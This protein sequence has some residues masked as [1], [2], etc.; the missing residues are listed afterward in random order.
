MWDSPSWEQGGEGGKGRGPALAPTPAE[1]G[2]KH[3]SLQP[4]LSWGLS[5]QGLAC[6]FLVE[7]LWLG[8]GE[9]NPAC[10]CPACQPGSPWWLPPAL[11][12]LRDLGIWRG[13]A[14]KAARGGDLEKDG[15]GSAAG[16]PD[17]IQVAD[18]RHFQAKLEPPLGGGEEEGRVPRKGRETR[19]T[20]DVDTHW[21]CCA[22]CCCRCGLCRPHAGQST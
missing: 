21:P 20:G 3:F 13:T 2:A 11:S 22:F 9:P 5:H 12:A 16:D 18:Q 7:T 4:Q 15:L 14:E 19:S 10:S 17:H 6:L 1:L 8:T